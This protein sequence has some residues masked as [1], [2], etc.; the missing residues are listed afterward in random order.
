MNNPF[1]N[2]G[3]YRE[4]ANRSVISLIDSQWADF[5][6][7]P[8]KLLYSSMRKCSR[9][10]RI[11][12]YKTHVQPILNYASPV[13]EMPPD[14]GPTIARNGLWY[15]PIQGR[16]LVYQ[17]SFL[18]SVV[19]QWNTLPKEIQSINDDRDS[20]KASLIQHSVKL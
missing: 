3:Y 10:S 13:L 11:K 16:V 5:Q 8:A 20:F 15:N 18:P 1:V 12:A 9:N 17:N 6:T 4:D 14:F 19:K 2:F 7:A